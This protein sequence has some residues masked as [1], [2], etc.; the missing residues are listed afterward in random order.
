M[1]VNNLLDRLARH[2]VKLKHY[3]DRQIS[4]DILEAKVQIE[5][6]ERSEEALAIADMEFARM[7]RLRE[8]HAAWSEVTFPGIGPVGPLKHLSKEALEAAERPQEPEE[9]ADCLFLLWDAVRRAGFTMDDVVSAGFAKLEELKTRTY[10]APVDGQPCEH[11]REPE[12]ASGGVVTG[13]KTALVGE[14]GGE[15]ILP[16][17]REPVVL[18][19]DLSS[20]GDATVTVVV[21][22]EMK[23]KAEEV[24]KQVAEKKRVTPGAL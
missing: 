9:Y 2:A 11:V 24:I 22:A 14:A 15:A 6:F 1:D 8:A 7:E 19:M 17:N 12:F 13:G 5:A 18:G 20:G 3:G 16:I 23:A 21:N 4:A 10:P